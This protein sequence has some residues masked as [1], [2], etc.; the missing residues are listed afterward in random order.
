MTYVRPLERTDAARETHLQ[1]ASGAPYAD[2]WL[3]DNGTD[4]LLRTSPTWASPPARSRKLPAGP[5]EAYQA[6]H[7][8]GLNYQAAQV[9]FMCAST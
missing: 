9:T 1:R 4:G 6:H 2:A 3:A 5:V 8:E 7:I